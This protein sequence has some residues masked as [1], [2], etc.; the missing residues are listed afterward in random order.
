MFGERAWGEGCMLVYII[1][2]QTRKQVTDSNPRC[3][4]H[5][6]DVLMY[7]EFRYQHAKEK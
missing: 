2:D 6:D 4:H 1:T 5:D 3:G 7:E